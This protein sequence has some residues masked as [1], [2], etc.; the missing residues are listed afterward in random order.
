MITKIYNSP[1]RNKRFR[2]DIK[3]KDGIKKIDFGLRG[4]F[5]Y[6]D[7]ASDIVKRNY[8]KRHMGNATENRLITNLVPSAS[9]LSAKLLWGPTRDLSKNIAELNNMWKD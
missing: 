4:G 6:L 9:L 1:L 5:T 3:T 7:G 2:A 8:L